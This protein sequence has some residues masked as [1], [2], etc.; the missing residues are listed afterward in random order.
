MS[1]YV[2]LNLPAEPRTVSYA[3][4]F[5]FSVFITS[6]QIFYS[7]SH[8]ATKGKPAIESSTNSSVR[9]LSVG[10]IED[11][12]RISASS[13]A[14][15]TYSGHHFILTAAHALIGGCEY[16]KVAFGETS[17][18]CTKIVASDSKK[19]YVIFETEEISN[20]VPY[21]IRENKIQETRP[22]L[23]DRTVYT[24]Y[25]NGNGPTT[26]AG[27]VAGLGEDRL[28]VQSYAWPGSSG[29]GLFSAKGELIGVV[30]AL[31]VGT[32]SYGEQV[33]EN[34]VVVTPVGAMDWDKL[35]SEY[36]K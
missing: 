12:L 21:R 20:R 13:G 28:L 30:T 35:F 9:V 18:A 32:S 1:N 16:T 34:V 11:K 25:P 10:V 4:L 24:G 2:P 14:Y 27:T 6:G 15:L 29:A 19:D 17:A 7:R 3:L 36:N 26:W 8:A 22:S 31:D 5:L 33:L 23:L